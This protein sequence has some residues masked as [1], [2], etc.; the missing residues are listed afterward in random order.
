MVEAADRLAELNTEISLAAEWGRNKEARIAQ[1]AL[2]VD[3]T[4]WVEEPECE[5]CYNPL[6][7]DD[8]PQDFDFY[9]PTESLPLAWAIAETEEDR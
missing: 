5:Y 1:V 3:L 6:P 7:C 4:G 9:W 8:T 2:A